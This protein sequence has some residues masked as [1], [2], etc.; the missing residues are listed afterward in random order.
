MAGRVS[1][2]KWVRYRKKI[3][4]SL[5][6]QESPGRTRKFMPTLHSETRNKTTPHSRPGPFG[7]KG[8]AVAAGL[9]GWNRLGGLMAPRKGKSCAYG[10][11]KNSGGG[12]LSCLPAEGRKP[13][14]WQLPSTI[15]TRAEDGPG[16]WGCRAASASA[17][18]ED[19]YN[20]TAS[21][22]AGTG[23]RLANAEH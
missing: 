17:R 2:S 4:E 22:M 23:E 18:P 19:F 15:T 8:S 13:Q 3:K 21:N 10:K 7:L 5:K 12:G 11:K 1:F 9:K 20:A 6:G 14:A 16:F